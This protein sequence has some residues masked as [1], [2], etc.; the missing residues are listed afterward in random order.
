MFQSYVD[1]QTQKL[2]D[3]PKGKGKKY[4]VGRYADII[5]TRAQ[6]VE[7]LRDYFD[8]GDPNKEASRLIDYFDY[9]LFPIKK[10]EFEQYIDVL[11]WILDA[12]QKG[13]TCPVY[14]GVEIEDDGIA[15]YLWTR[16]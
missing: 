13:Q 8:V 9:C 15:E 2:F 11:L 1:M 7:L 5:V 6:L 10:A 4:F 3:Q 12:Y 14:H 16:R